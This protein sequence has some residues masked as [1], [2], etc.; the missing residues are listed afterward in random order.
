MTR[1]TTCFVLDYCICL[2]L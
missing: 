2:T 1:D